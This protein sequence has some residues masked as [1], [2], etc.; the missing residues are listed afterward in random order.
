MINPRLLEISMTRYR[1][2]NIT[3]NVTATPIRYFYPENVEDIQAIVIEAEKEKLRVR[4][5]GS[6]HSFSEA[7][8]GSDFMM[9]MKRLRNAKLYKTS[10]KASYQQNHYVIADAGITIRRINRLLDEMG[11]ALENMGAV[12]FQTISG[13]L[14][15]GT[16]GT[17]IK[18]PAFPD[19]VRSL[20]IVATGG[21]LIQI[22]P[23]DGITDPSLHAASESFKLIQDDDI[24][25]STVLSFGG[26]G[27]VYQI[28][29]E[30]VPRF[31]IHEMRYLEKWSVLKQQLLS[32]DFMDKVHD[33]DFVAF[34]VNPYEIKGDHLVSVVV[35][36]VVN[37]PVGK[38]KG[39]RNPLTR[40]FSNREAILEGV[41]KSL[42]RNPKRTPKRIQM[43][44]KSSAVKS[45]T[46]ISYK[47]LYQSGS[48]VLRYGLSSEFAFDATA[49][50]IIEVLEFIFHQ[51]SYYE[52]YAELNHPAHI[53]VRFVKPSH[54]YLSS[55]Y[56]RP[57]VYVDVPTLYNSIGYMSLM[58][59]YQ[60]AMIKMGGIPHWGKINNILYQNHQFIKDQF[61][62]VDTWIKVRKQMD[63]K[64]TFLNDFIIAMGLA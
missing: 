38:H 2:Y 17:G 33:N 34:R 37:A 11:L 61:P 59:R 4:A 35:Q 43:M 19:M 46:D 41:I 7:A 48:A 47:V 6:G 52:E 57:T 22:E 64:G 45:Y 53:A 50:K 51:T 60:H 42:D 55:A 3:N 12:D 36:N 5:V 40:L 29:F 8:K 54:A 44:I 49:V 32:G 31:M 27:I 9:D 56:N 23:T 10:V 28:V 20:R 30:V 14:M 62:M 25:Y 58:E 39:M 26:M 13:A 18:K 63:P 21:E 16:H 15:T 1:W 24:F